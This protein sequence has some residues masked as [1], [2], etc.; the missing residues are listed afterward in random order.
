MTRK[1]AIVVLGERDAGKSTTWNDLFSATVRTGQYVRGLTIKEKWK[2]DNVFLVSGSLQ[3]RE[4]HPT[5][6]ITDKIHEILLISV[7]YIAGARDTLRFLIENKYEIHCHWINPGHDVDR[8]YFDYL[9]LSQEYLHSSVT[10]TMLSSKNLDDRIFRIQE[11]ILGWALLNG[12]L[13]EIK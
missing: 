7:Q 3:E 5:E 1:L 6:V 10:I 13:K 2:V 12:K 8:A 11:V 9:G 4:K